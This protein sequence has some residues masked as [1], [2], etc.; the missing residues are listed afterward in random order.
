MELA[1]FIFVEAPSVMKG[2]SFTGFRKTFAPTQSRPY[3][4]KTMLNCL[5]HVLK[6][7]GFI[8]EESKC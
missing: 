2:I 7:P 8:A 3:I 4:E 1:A 5:L 6:H